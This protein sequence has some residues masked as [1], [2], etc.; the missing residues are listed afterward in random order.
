MLNIQCVFQIHLERHPSGNMLSAYAWK[1]R[2]LLQI[3][4][5]AP[6][7]GA[8]CAP[9]VE[10]NFTWDEP[11]YESHMFSGKSIPHEAF[12][13]TE[14]IDVVGRH[15][16]HGS[17]PDSAA[18]FVRIGDEYRQQRRASPLVPISFPTVR[19]TCAMQQPP[20]YTTVILAALHAF[21]KAKMNK[22]E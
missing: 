10:G 11:G 12:L 20:V 9:V 16:P 2:S 22:S 5:I 7:F 21:C 13:I 18:R 6:P 17:E 14:Y 15:Q 4:A 19:E 3:N 8:Y 1:W